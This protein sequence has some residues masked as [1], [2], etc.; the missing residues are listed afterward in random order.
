MVSADMLQKHFNISSYV[1]VTDYIGGAITNKNTDTA[2][3]FTLDAWTS[4]YGTS[5]DGNTSGIW[6]RIAK[7]DT[8]Y[9]TKYAS[10]EG[11][12]WFDPEF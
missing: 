9:T 7:G 5:Y 12:I 11:R 3:L 6:G 10:A 4:G 8:D 1:P 2:S